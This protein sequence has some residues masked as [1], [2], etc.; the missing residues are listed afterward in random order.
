MYRVQGKALGQYEGDGDRFPSLLQ[1]SEEDARVT[2]EHLRQT[3]QKHVQIREQH[4]LLESALQKMEKER[5]QLRGIADDQE[6][7]SGNALKEERDGM[8][9]QVEELENKLQARHI[10]ICSLENFTLENSTKIE[11]CVVIGIR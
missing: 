4:R 3:K 7:L 5:D 2:R 10:S 8:V 9:K 11:W 1:R 6:L